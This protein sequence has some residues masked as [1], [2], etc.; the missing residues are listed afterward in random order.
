M[1]FLRSLLISTPLIVFSTIGMGTLS[2]LASFFDRQ[3]NGLHHLARIWGKML[4]AESFIRVRT[5]GLEKLDPRG[6]YVFVANHASYMDIPAIL[7]QLPHQFR[8]FAKKGL[9]KIPFL[10]T[11]LLRAG[12]LPV[13]RSSPRASLKSMTEAARIIAT[14]STCMLLFPEGGRSPHGLREFKEGAAYIAIKAGV[15]VV[16][17]AL[18]GMRELLPMGSIHIRTGRVT[19]RIGNP[20]PTKNLKL[21]DREAL[22]QRLH[23]EIAGMLRYD[24]IDG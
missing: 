11:H 19:L 3:G 22:T 20:I 10:G 1:S 14:R 9:Y 7:S 6:T 4:L 13:D 18:V 5:E 24:R 16:P 21:A 23:D 2:I 17:M 8:F 15:P 12:H